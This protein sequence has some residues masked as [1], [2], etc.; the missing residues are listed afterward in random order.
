MSWMCVRAV[1]CRLLTPLATTEMNF[2]EELVAEWYE[3]QGYFVRRNVLVGPSEKVVSL[4]S[5]QEV[6]AVANVPD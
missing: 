4:L 3:Y 5:E 6:E 2:L 1:W